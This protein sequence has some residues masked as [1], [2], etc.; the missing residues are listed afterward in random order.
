MTTTMTPTEAIAFFEGQ[1]R[2]D[3]GTEGFWQVWGARASHI[4]AGDILLSKVGDTDEVGVDYITEVFKAKSIVRQGFINQR[5][6]H[7]TI[8]IGA[9]IILVRWGTHNTLAS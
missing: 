2:K 1:D 4:R 3:P 7:L 9:P 8:G 6:E 5:G